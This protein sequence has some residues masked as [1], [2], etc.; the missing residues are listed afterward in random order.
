[1]FSK[2]VL[3][4]PDAAYPHCHCATIVQLSCGDLLVAWYAYPQEETRGGVLMLARKRSNGA[5]F[6][7]PRRILAE[8]NSSLGNPLLFC[9]AEGRVQLL[10]V[11]LRGHYWDSAVIN[12]C[13]STDGGVTWSVPESLRTDPGVMVRYAPVQRKNTYFLLPAYDERINQTVLMTA[14]PGAEGWFPVEHFNG[15]KSIQGS[16]VRQSD[17]DLTMLLRPT[18]E[19][20]VCL[21]S[22]SCDD[23]RS[24]SSVLRTT[25]PNPLSGV[26]AFQMGDALCAVYNHTTEHR[27]YPLSLSYSMDRGTSWTGPIHIDETQ[28]EVSYPSFIVDDAG[29]AHGVYTF[30]R[31]R[32]Y[33]VTFDNHWWK[34]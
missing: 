33:Y 34:R 20:R 13:Y 30:G 3:A 19:D 22:I 2:G 29:V 8:L 23:G 4:N 32:I 24:W 5:T 12:R 21:R 10:F 16:I 28:H 31:N 27:R 26:V 25:L 7:R 15:I 9:D 17:T 11:A 18:G 1:M 14:D 6:D